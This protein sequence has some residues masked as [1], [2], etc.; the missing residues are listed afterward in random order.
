MSWVAISIYNVGFTGLLAVAAYLIRSKA[1]AWMRNILYLYFLVHVFLLCVTP[2]VI[3]LNPADA[4][5]YL[6]IAIGFLSVD[7]LAFV[8]LIYLFFI[9]KIFDAMNEREDN[10]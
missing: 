5:A 10:I 3:A 6:P 9:N 8:Y 7:L 1:L 4:T 2:V